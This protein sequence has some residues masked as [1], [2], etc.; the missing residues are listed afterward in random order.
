M[1][2]LW[3]GRF[4][5]GIKLISKEPKFMGTKMQGAAQGRSPRIKALLIQ[6]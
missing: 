6:V 5:K 3:D 4:Q 1:K 2:I